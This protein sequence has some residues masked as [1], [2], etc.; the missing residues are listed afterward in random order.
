VFLCGELGAG[1]TTLAAALL[2]ALGVEETVRSPSYALVEV[3]MAGARQAVHM[4]LYRLN[5]SQELEQLGPRDYLNANTLLLVEWPERADGALPRPDLQ[6][7][8]EPVGT[9][10]DIGRNACIEARSAAGEQW[11]SQI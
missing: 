9:G 11:L 2:N 5:G 6:V 4:D 10:A 8:L 7:L 1:K 3:Y